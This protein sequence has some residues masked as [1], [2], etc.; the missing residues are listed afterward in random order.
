[1]S[2]HL[3]CVQKQL[4]EIASILTGRNKQQVRMLKVGFGSAYSMRKHIQ[5][6]SRYSG[7]QICR[8]VCN[9]VCDT[10]IVYR[11]RFSHIYSKLHVCRHIW[12]RQRDRDIFL[13]NKQ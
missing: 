6:I 10:K 9:E 12:S 1:M 13:L 5:D 4:V 2:V 3:M 8:N 7:E 11:Q